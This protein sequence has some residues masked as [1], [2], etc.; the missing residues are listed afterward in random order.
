MVSIR[1]ACM[2]DVLAMQRCNLFCLPENYQLKYYFYHILS[3]PHL[4]YVAADYDGSIVGYVMAK[5]DEKASDVQYGHVTSLAVLRTHRKLGIATK[6][7]KAAHGAMQ[8]VYDAHYVT[9]HVR[10][11][12]KAACHLYRETLGYEVSEVE[13]KYYADG[14]NAFCMKKTLKKSRVIATGNKP[15]SAD[16]ASSAKDSSKKPDVQVAAV[17]A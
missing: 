6:L 16:R 9:L 14:E 15:T 10:I 4:L 3:W 13:T 11:S 2:D 7:M 12:N 1:A 5:L 8:D 17:T